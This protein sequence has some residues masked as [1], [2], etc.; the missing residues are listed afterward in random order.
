MASP[1]RKRTSGGG[2]RISMAVL[3]N[4]DWVTGIRFVPLHPPSAPRAFGSASACFTP[5]S[6]VLTSFYGRLRPWLS[7]ALIGNASAHASDTKTCVPSR[8][9]FDKETRRKPLAFAADAAVMGTGS[10]FGTRS[11]AKLV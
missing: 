10:D 9:V 3:R 8:G 5:M 7:L 2:E 6:S 1:A 11:E 4:S